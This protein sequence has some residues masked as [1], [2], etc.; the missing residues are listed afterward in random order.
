MTLGR[1]PD[2]PGGP[3]GIAKAPAPAPRRA[4]AWAGLAV[5]LGLSVLGGCAPDAQSVQGVPVAHPADPA[6]GEAVFRAGGCAACHATPGSDARGVPRLGGGLELVT[7]QGTFRAPNISPH[8]ADGIGAWTAEDFAGAMLQGIAPDG[9]HYYPAFPYPSYSRMTASDVNDLRAY[10]RTLPPVPGKAAGHDLRFPYGNRGLLG[11][12]KSLYLRSGK[13]VRLEGATAEVA[14]G[15]YLVEG[16]GHCGACHTPR[17]A[18]GGPDYDR[19]LGGGNGEGHAAAPD[20]TS[21]GPGI[22][23]RTVEEIAAALAPSRTHRQAGA[24]GSGME[25]VR[26]DLA[27]LAADDRLAIAAYLKAVPAAPGPD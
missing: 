6:R 15:Q 14:R 3:E 8:K 12:W 11:F 1:A 13:V 26:R 16:P 22:A 4:P 19:W 7:R 20:I 10:L 27:H 23:G 18:F 5:I 9:R 17:T 24:Y 21:A 25:A 2:R